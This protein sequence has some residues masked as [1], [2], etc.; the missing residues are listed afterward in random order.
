MYCG[1]RRMLFL[2]GRPA[3]FLCGC[4]DR[5]AVK[6]FCAARLLDDVLRDNDRVLLK[7]PSFRNLIEAEVEEDEYA[8]GVKRKNYGRFFDESEERN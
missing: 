3:D 2:L 6:I 7:V 8:G 1:A 5:L 4:F